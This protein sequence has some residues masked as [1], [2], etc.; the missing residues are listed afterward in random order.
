M[1][2]EGQEGIPSW[3]TVCTWAERHGT[4]AGGLPGVWAL[5]Q[6]RSLQRPKGKG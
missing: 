3:G 2:V 5:V 1:S 6:A 4:E